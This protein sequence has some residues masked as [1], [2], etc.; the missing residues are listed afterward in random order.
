V[1]SLTRSRS[2]IL[3]GA[4]AVIIVLLLV[5][6]ANV[7][8][9]PR[10]TGLVELHAAM[11]NIDDEGVIYVDCKPILRASGAGR[12]EKRVAV[13][14]DAVITTQVDNDLNVYSWGVL[15]IVEGKTIIRSER[16]RVGSLGANRSDTA[17][18][19][20]TVF[21]ESVAADGTPTKAPMCVRT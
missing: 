18:A 5:F 16:G 15:V 19:F 2:A 11:W 17:R 21:D 1:H 4:T 14:P 20:E 7:G 13:A 9:A 12:R 8:E 3:T 10:D 6:L